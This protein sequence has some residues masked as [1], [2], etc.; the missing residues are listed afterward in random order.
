VAKVWGLVTART[1]GALIGTTLLIG[2]AGAAYAGTPGA[3][4]RAAGAADH[5]RGRRT[6]AQNQRAA[7]RAAEEILQGL[8]FPSGTSPSSQEPTGDKGRLKHPPSSP[9]TPNLI[10]HHSWWTTRSSP[11]QVLRYV[12]DHPP[13]G[14]TWQQTTSSGHCPPP[15]KYQ[16]PNHCHWLWWVQMYSF[17]PLPDTLGSRVL[18]VKIARLANGRLGIR[19]DAQA[20]WISPRPA[21]EKVPSG[22]SEVDVTQAKPGRPPTVSKQVVSPRKVRRIIHLIDQLP[23]TQPEL[24]DCAPKG[25]GARID[26]FTFRSSTRAELAHASSWSDVGNSTTHCDAMRFSFHGQSRPAL[27]QTRGFLTDVGKLLGLRLATPQ[28]QPPHGY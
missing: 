26:T 23:I 24:P 13:R 15:P 17:S 28:Y 10:D 8:S 27:A 5:M 4:A 22:V 16:S 25:P 12:E 7:N 6:A 20:V 21:G 9:A 11:S 2:F 14:G 1:A 3:G 19:A 18:L